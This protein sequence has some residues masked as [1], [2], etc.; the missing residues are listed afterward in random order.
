MNLRIV[1]EEA[2]TPELDEAIRH[3]LVVCFPADAESFSHTRAWHGSAPAWSV[4]LDHE[5][6][7]IGHVGVVD[8]V[9]KVGETALR[10]AGIQNV[11]LLPE[12]RGR[13]VSTPLM[14]K[15][16]HEAAAQGFDLGMLFCVPALERVY[17]RAGWLSLGERE[18]VRIDETGVEV[19]LPAKNVCLFFPLAHPSFPR[20]VIHLQGNDW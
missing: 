4:I 2:V 10:V 3:G 20:G 5:G 9:I 19:P 18:T 8:R 13:G 12:F 7:V 15:A 1:K 17:S 6:E 11:F 14:D 16:M